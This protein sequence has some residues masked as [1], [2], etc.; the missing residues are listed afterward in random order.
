MHPPP[1]LDSRC[2]MFAVDQAFDPFLSILAKCM[3]KYQLYTTI[4]SFLRINMYVLSGC[5]E[6]NGKSTISHWKP[7]H[8]V[9]WS[10][11]LFGGYFPATIL[12]GVNAT[13]SVQERQIICRNEKLF[14]RVPMHWALIKKDTRFHSWDHRWDKKTWILSNCGMSILILRYFHVNC[15]NRRLLFRSS[16]EYIWI[17]CSS[18]PKWFL[19]GLIVT[20]K[21]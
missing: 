16:A 17:T 3:P 15:H 12:P 11:S 20:S 13:S 21:L 5:P 2:S 18:V 6:V 7:P 1:P 4:S 8:E 9:E 10:E 19:C 14:T